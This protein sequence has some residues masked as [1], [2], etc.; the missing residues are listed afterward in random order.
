MSEG[1]RFSLLERLGIVVGVL[2]ALGVMFYLA[3]LNH[4]SVNH[5][6]IAY[7]SLDG[8]ISEQDPGW[9]VTPPT[10]LTTSLSTLPLTVKIPSEAR[11][12]NQKVVRFRKGKVVEFVKF[13]G[14]SWS[15]G[16]SLENILLGYAYSGR[17]WPFLEVLDSTDHDRAVAS[18]GS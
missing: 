11:I 14:W 9:H 6:G 17:E 18:A 7:N 3:C 8:A 16:D 5:I 1:G 13:Q 4:V 15:L 2:V 12:I 10:V